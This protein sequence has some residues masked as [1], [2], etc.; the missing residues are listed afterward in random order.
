MSTFT[1]SLKHR[2][3]E[4]DPLFR[5]WLSLGGDAAAEAPRARRLRLA[6]DRH[7]HCAQRQRRRDLA[8][9]CDRR[10]ASAERTG[11]ASAGQRGVARQA[12]DGCRRAHAD[13]SEH[14][15]RRRSGA[16]GA[17]H[18]ISERREAVDGLRGVAGVVRAAAYGMRRD[19]VQTANAQ[20]ATIVQ[21]ESAR[22]LDE[23]EKIAA[24]PGVDC[25]F[26]GPADLRGEPRPSRRF[27]ARRR[28]GGHG[29]HR[30]RGRQGGHRSR[31]FFDGRRE[32]KAASRQR[33]S[34]YRSGRRRHVDVAR[35]PPGVAG[36]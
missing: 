24:T 15:V 14:R 30:Q 17:A 4:A 22:G 6:A 9:A 20:I 12:C 28:A 33:F 1:K 21:I 19:Y 16:R 8:I 36:E 2:L 23:V 31:H 25:L 13:V 18:A 26:V 35:N 3:E 32:R 34:F 27:E 7:G 29:A 11:G 10:R 5:L